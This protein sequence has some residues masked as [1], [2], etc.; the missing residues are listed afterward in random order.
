M[1]LLSAMLLSLCLSFSVWADDE[2]LTAMIDPIWASYIG[3]GTGIIGALTGISGAIVGFI[4]YR[5]ISSLKS[6]D[7][8]IA[9]KSAKDEFEVSM[10]KLNAIANK[11]V[12]SRPRIASAIGGVVSGMMTEWQQDI[13]ARKDRTTELIDHFSSR[14]SNYDRMSANELENALVELRRWKGLTDAIVGEYEGDLAWDDEQGRQLK[15]DR[16]AFPPNRN[17]SFE[18]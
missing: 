17:S 12:R 1:K 15:E 3:M 11:A 14:Q 16:R 8:R 2:G 4:S 7:L 10:R 9:T 6:L 13:D 18:H 5:K